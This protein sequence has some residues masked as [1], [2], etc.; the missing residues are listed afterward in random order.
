[1][2]FKM[3]DGQSK[4]KKREDLPIVSHVCKA[5]GTSSPPSKNVSPLNGQ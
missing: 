4:R 1:M 3:Y 5:V 2:F